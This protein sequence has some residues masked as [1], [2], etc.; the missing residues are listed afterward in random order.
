MPDILT[1]N[2]FDADI[3]IDCLVIG[4]GAAGMTAGIILV[5]SSLPKT[6]AWM[7]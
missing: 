3:D 5:T 6:T 7:D 2:V 4:G 1:E